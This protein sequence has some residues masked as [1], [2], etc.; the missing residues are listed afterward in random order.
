[1]V[2]DFAA[3]ERAHLSTCTPIHRRYRR[4]VVIEF[5]IGNGAVPSLGDQ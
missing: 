4:R 5:L 2:G 1:M 3:N